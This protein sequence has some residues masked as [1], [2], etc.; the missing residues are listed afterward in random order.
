MT[1]RI[2]T[3]RKRPS[4][5]RGERPLQR[6]ARMRSAGALLAAT[7]TVAGAGTIATASAAPPTDR[8]YELVSPVDD[9]SGSIA[10][11]TSPLVPA[12]AIASADGDRVLYG[13]VS[14][15]G[16]PWSGVTNAMVFGSRTANRWAASTATVSLD[17]GDTPTEIATSEP[18]GGR[19][20]PDGRSFVFYTGN[21]GAM[22]VVP[23]QRL[24]GVFRATDDGN[25]P[26]WL[27]RP[28]DGITPV[29]TSGATNQV[30]DNISISRDGDTVAFQANQPLAAG[31]PS[32]TTSSVY[33]SRNGQVELAS[34]YPDGS[35]VQSY[36]ELAC[37]VTEEAQPAVVTSYCSPLAGGGRYVLFRV[38]SSDGVYVRDLQQQQTRQLTGTAVGR[39]GVSN[40]DAAARDG[41]HAFF[42]YG[43]VM[44]EADLAA[45]TMTVTPRPAITGKPFGLTADGRQMLFLESP[46]AVNG[47]SWTLRFWDGAADPDDS[48]RVGTVGAATVPLS[49]GGNIRLRVFRSQDAGQTWIFGA[50]GSL[51]PARPSANGSTLQ[52]YRWSVGDDA[53][54]CLS[55]QPVDNVARTTGINLTI[56]EVVGTEMMLDPTVTSTDYLADFGFSTRRLSQPGHSVSDDGRWILFD[57]PD[58]LV[59]GDQNNV[60]DVYLWDRDAP[61]G[62]Q[63]QLVTSGQGST[64]S[65]ALDLDPTGRNAFFSTR[66][67]LL[68]ADRNGNYD[69]YVARVGGGF[70]NEE[71]P[72]DGEKEC[73]PPVI[74]DP[75]QGPIG[76]GHLTPPSEG[77]KQAVQTGTPKLRVRSV[78]TTSRR[79]T[80]RIDTPRAGKIRVTGKSVRTTSRTAKRAATYTL[81]VPLSASAQRQVARGRSVKVG[82]R[83][84]FTATGAKK[85]SAVRTTV[86]VRKGR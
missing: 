3:D 86:T 60:R 84:A 69:V 54:T 25:P 47:N 41:A 58:R 36:T 78:R 22:P 73:R 57:S 12:P 11:L 8:A 28:A 23:G 9:P 40:L 34:R 5:V 44:Q 80:V 48:I 26:T 18:R 68:P 49:T 72:C 16:S 37:V 52:L 74:P 77:N 38:G 79:L 20:T 32:A 50:T 75:P 46:S 15:L 45:S 42:T 76:S 53:P 4:V 17:R 33:A 71:D 21:L 43:G 6:A 19:L 1:R 63:L 59:A 81:R 10:G 24:P 61:D 29:P 2:A 62:K 13:T 65:Y 27:S 30:R 7:L 56:Q 83:V 85:A 66:E 51:D 64:P 82:L 55:C 31:A 70:P 39:P 67:S 35:A 14:G